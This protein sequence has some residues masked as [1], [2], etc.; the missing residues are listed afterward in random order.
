MV[1][2]FLEEIEAALSRQARA[3]GS[4]QSPLLGANGL[5]TIVDFLQASLAI[6]VNGP[7]NTTQHAPRQVYNPAAKASVRRNKFVKSEV[8]H[9]RIPPANLR[10][11]RL[12][13]PS[14]SPAAS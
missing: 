2:R 8:S 13:P 11:C 9:R 1:E 3:G 7:P 4:V 5:H 10:F 14:V 12:A 6:Q